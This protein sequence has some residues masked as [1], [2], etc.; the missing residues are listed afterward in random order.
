MNACQSLGTLTASAH[1]NHHAGWLLWQTVVSLS[2]TMYQLGTW[3]LKDSPLVSMSA[4]MEPDKHAACM[5]PTTTKVT[6][7]PQ[8]LPHAH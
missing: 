1:L 8:V 7:L 3:S 5:L 4:S 6:V 2:M